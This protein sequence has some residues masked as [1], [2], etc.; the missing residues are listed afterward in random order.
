MQ[1]CLSSKVP[2]QVAGGEEG[3]PAV[4]H[5]GATAGP[6][7]GELRSCSAATTAPAWHRE[8]GVAMLGC[9]RA[10][11]RTYTHIHPGLSVRID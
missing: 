10:S 5:A 3:V 11:L 6:A 4:Q 9:S 2:H 1:T 7:G 8:P